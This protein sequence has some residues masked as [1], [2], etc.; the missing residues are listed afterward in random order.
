MLIGKLHAIIAAQLLGVKGFSL[1]IFDQVRR[2]RE[3]EDL[4]RGQKQAEYRRR[5]DEEQRAKNGQAASERRGRELLDQ[6]RLPA[7]IDGFQAARGDAKVESRDWQGQHVVTLTW[8]ATRDLGWGYEDKSVEIAA[9][10]NGNITVTSSNADLER[11]DRTRTTV[12]EL[13]RNGEALLTEAYKK[14]KAYRHP[15]PDHQ[16]C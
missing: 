11:R 8:G 3:N 15:H 14:A 13:A 12:Q 16:G 10:G 7:L 5:L 6:S 1:G 2:D 9:D 4:A